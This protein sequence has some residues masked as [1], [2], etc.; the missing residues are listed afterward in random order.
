MDAERSEEETA[1]PMT[2]GG[3]RRG[4]LRSDAG[5]SMSLPA[6]H[7]SRGDTRVRRSRTLSRTLTLQIVAAGILAVVASLALL[8]VLIQQSAT[9]AA[10]QSARQRAGA[11]ADAVGG[12]F[13]QW[14]DELLVADQD[15]VLRDWY[16]HPDLREALRPEMDALLLQ[17]HSV[18]P[19]LIDEA[20]VIDASGVE[21]ARQA[22][23]QTAPVSDLS[24]DESRA[25]FFV[26]TLKQPAGGVAQGIVYRS[27]DSG[28]WV[29]ANAT[30]I[31]IDGHN[32]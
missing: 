22:K 24:P 32:A 31:R 11:V 10:E 20:C 25:P 1:L 16:R 21:F 2:G 7:A 9:E 29:V 23:G 18:F 28:R 13:Q 4:R 3:G 14:H 26:P 27:E 5:G 19:D 12:L 30:P 6:G 8:A 17:L 15:T